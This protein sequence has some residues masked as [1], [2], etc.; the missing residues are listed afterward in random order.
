MRLFTYIFFLL[1]LATCGGGGESSPTGPTSSIITQPHS[2]EIFEVKTFNLVA[3]SSL[4]EAITFSIASQPTGGQVTINGSEATYNPN[5]GFY[6]LDS[7][8]VGGTHLVNKFFHQILE[9]YSR[10]LI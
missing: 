8:H 9:Y 5:S 2:V 7:F 6:G 4:G 1:F 10:L 3:S